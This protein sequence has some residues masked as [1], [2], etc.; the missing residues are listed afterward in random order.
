MIYRFGDF[1]LDADQ[2]E[3]RRDGVRLAVEPQVFALLHLLVARRERLVSRDEIIEEVWGG[4]FI[5]EAAVSSRIKFCRQALGDNGATQQWIRTIHGQGF[6]FVGEVTVEGDGPAPVAALNPAERVAEVMARPMVAVF[7]FEQENPDPADAYFVDGLAEDLMTELASWRWLPILSRN[8]AFD[9]SRR[10]LPIAER[11]AALGARYA[12]G[13]RIQRVGQQARLSIELVDAAGGAQLWSARF[14]R[15]MAG[16]VEMRGQIAAEVF[17]RIAPELTSAERRR[18]L[19]KAPE[20]LTAWDLTLKALWALNHASQDD[21]AAA[22]EQLE[23]ATRLDPASALPWNLISFIHYETALRGWAGGQREVMVRL[24]REVLSAAQKAVAIDP[25][26]WMGHSLASIGELWG[27]ASYTR[28]RFHAE[29]ALE[30]NPSAGLAHHFSGCVYGFGGDLDE[31]IAIQSQAFRID[32]DYLHADVIEADL[33][34]WRFLLGDL[35]HA[36]THLERAIALNP[37]N[38]RARQR[39][40]ALLGSLGDLDA[41]CEERSRLE[42]LSGPLT[43]EYLA[44]SYPFQRPEHFERLA[45]GLRRGGVSL[46]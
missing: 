25:S 24:L 39:M 41:A 17:Q 15:D 30:L 13:G 2:I 6:R 35:E 3:L 36:R 18:I 1:E 31:A 19:R 4:R 33:G 27:A 43:A 28:A 44:A 9:P 7:P 11:P 32:P 16:L 8:A 38:A 10:G 40:V 22:L 45:D 23:T 20:D 21:F 12:I 37:Q 29:Q 34:L 26:G 5:S 42:A 46:D 14:E